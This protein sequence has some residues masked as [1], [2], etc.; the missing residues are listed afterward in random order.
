MDGD[1]GLDMDAELEAQAPVH[2]SHVG[3]NTR[4]SESTQNEGDD[5]DPSAQ[6]RES[7]SVQKH[8][9]EHDQSDAFGSSV[10]ASA[11]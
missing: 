6:A 11:R 8:E 9:N 4:S 5:F 7:S 10:S 2:V 1:V 3:A